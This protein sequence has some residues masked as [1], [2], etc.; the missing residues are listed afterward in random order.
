[1]TLLNFYI[2]GTLIMTI[3]VIIQKK[4]LERTSL[5]YYHSQPTLGIVFSEEVFLKLFFTITILLSWINIVI[6]SHFFIKSIPL[7]IS[8]AYLKYKMRKQLKE[9]KRVMEEHG[10]TG[11]LKTQIEDIKRCLNNLKNK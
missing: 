1:M 5:Y 8:N 3:L 7:R 11:E 10:E 6:T 4:S 9:L 2:L